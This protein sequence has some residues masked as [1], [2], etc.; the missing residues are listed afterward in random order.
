M[1]YLIAY[2]I[3]DDR[4]RARLA[5]RL[6]DFGPRLQESLFLAHIDSS[7]AQHLHSAI[8]AEIDLAADTVHIFPLCDACWPKA[9]AHPS[10]ALPQDSPFFII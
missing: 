3:A 2:D 5:S 4:R 10:H 9:M 6:L 8:S 1:R 7:R